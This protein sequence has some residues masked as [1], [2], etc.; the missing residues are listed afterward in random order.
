MTVGTKFT[1][2]TA[3]TDMV[4]GGQVT[5]NESFLL[6][7][8]SVYFNWTAKY[9][10]GNYYQYIYGIYEKIILPPN[11]FGDGADNSIGYCGNITPAQAAVVLKEEKK[12]EK[13]TVPNIEHGIT[14]GE[15]KLVQGAEFKWVSGQ[16]IESNL[17][18]ENTA[19]KNPAADT[20]PGSSMVNL[21]AIAAAPLAFSL[22]FAAGFMAI[23]IYEIYETVEGND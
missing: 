19:V 12:E 22:M 23:V 4:W 11:S 10:Q 1:Y 18:F 7:F 2:A 9:A 13:T 20:N 17:T 6:P 8:W 15:V 21:S 16:K 14:Y 5:Y 3:A